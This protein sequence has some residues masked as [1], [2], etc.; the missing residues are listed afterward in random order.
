MKINKIIFITILTI[1][2]GGLFAGDSDALIMLDKQWG[3]S[4]GTGAEFVSKDLIAIGTDG[5]VGFKEFTTIDPSAPP[6][7]G[8]KYAAGDY[9]VKYLSKEIAILVHSTKGDNAH[10]SMHVYQKHGD[11]WLVVAT[12]SSP[13]DK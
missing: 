1:V 6:P 2:T 7:P 5:I 9:K 11:K 8:G 13:T 12:A 4:E 10:A 3:S